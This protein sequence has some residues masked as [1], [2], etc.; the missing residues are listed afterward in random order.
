MLLKK[1]RMVNF[2]QYMGDQTI[3]FS[4][5]PDKNV[6]IFLGV[7]TGGKSTLVQ[8]FN[9]VLYGEAVFE[10]RKSKNHYLLN[11]IVARNMREG[12]TEKVLV[13]LTLEHK[14]IEYLVTREQIY[15]SKM[16][17]SA[18]ADSD[19]ILTLMHKQSD[20]QFRRSDVS[21]FKKINEILPQDLSEYFFF[22]GERITT[23]SEKTNLENAVNDI[24][25]LTPV[26]NMIDHLNPDYK[27]S[28][29]SEFYKDLVDDGQGEMSGLMKGRDSC[30]VALQSL[31]SQL[32]MQRQLQAALQ[33]GYDDA[34]S[35]LDEQKQVINLVKERDKLEIEK[36]QDQLLVESELDN[37][38]NKFGTNYFDIF[39]SPIM[40]MSIEVLK[41]EDMS[42]KG[43]PDMNATAIDYLVKRGYCICGAELKE[44]EEALKHIKMEQD[45]LPPKSIGVSIATHTSRA[46]DHLSR[47][48]PDLKDCKAAYDSYVRAMER[49]EK[50][51]KKI[52]D[53]SDQLLNTPDVSTLEEQ[54]QLAKDKLSE[55]QKRIDSINKNIGEQSSK[56]REMDDKITRISKNNH[57]NDKTYVCL[58]YTEELFNRMVRIYGVKQARNL[59]RL[60][61]TIKDVFPK[62]YH[63][64]RDIDID[65]KYRVTLTVDNEVI[66]K[67]TGLDTVK[68]FA[69]IASLLKMAKESI[70]DEDGVI[71]EPYPLVMDAPFSNADATHIKNISKILPIF[72]QQVII[73]LMDKDWEVAREN[74]SPY[75][76]KIYRIC[77]ENELLATIEEEA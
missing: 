52:D 1:L 47:V 28:V 39:S 35:A 62:M 14:N 10:R 4:T 12:Q 67:S 58:A 43:I 30:I 71:S 68:N 11:K 66:D 49:V 38:I 2:R 13:E 55:N 25:G 34:R 65:N 50:T 69:F 21:Y 56:K 5:L 61:A 40:E 31:E 73:A 32:E 41:S 77:K 37:I 70:S 17:G 45:Y 18:S 44:N 72:A 54:F 15:K 29:Y 16:S 7:N 60:R 33:R 57:V 46:E 9:W 74:I 6:T 63:G 59:E 20:G 36:K 26:K 3:E 48:V 27:N 23:V 22:D 42:D 76:A 53:I 24:M 8:A 75:V 51:K 19:P 64:K